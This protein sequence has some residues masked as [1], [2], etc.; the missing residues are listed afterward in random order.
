M[1]SDVKDELSQR[2]ITQ[3]D[4]EMSRKPPEL[5]PG[6]AVS[7]H[8]SPFNF[9]LHQERFGHAHLLPFVSAATAGGLRELLTFKI[10]HMDGIHGIFG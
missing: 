6:P 2:F 4:A 8:E 10:S 9:P 5:V 1:L 7:S 3:H